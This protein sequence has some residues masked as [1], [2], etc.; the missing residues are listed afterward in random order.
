MHILNCGIFGIDHVKLYT[1]FLIRY[2][3][4]NITFLITFIY[5]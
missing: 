4:S 3:M 5:I 2:I 1:S